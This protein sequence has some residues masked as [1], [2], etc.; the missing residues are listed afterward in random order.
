MFKKKNSFFALG[1]SGLVTL[2]II[3]FQPNINF[4]YDFESFFP[5][6]DGEL[7]FYQEFR[8]EF[9]NDNDYLLIA[10]GHRPDVFDS[11]FLEKASLLKKTIKGMERVEKVISLLDLEEPMIS[12]FGIRSQPL[13]EWDEQ[14]NLTRSKN[15]ILESNQWKKNLINETGNYILLL[16]HNQQMISKEEGDILYRN[17]FG[18]VENSGFTDFYIAGKIQAQGEFVNLMQDEFSSFLGISGVLIVLLLFL[19]FRTLW[20]ILIPLI[21][22]MIGFFWSIAIPLYLGKPLDI[23]SVM[24]PTILS[25]IGLAA[26]IHFFNQYLNYLRHG[27]TKEDAIEKSFLEILPAVFLTSLTTALGFASLYFTSVPTLKFFGLYTGLGVLV[28]FLSVILIIPGLLYIVPAFKQKNEEKNAENWRIGMR[29]AFSFVLLNKKT[30]PLI[31]LLIT[32]S[33]LFGVSRLKVNGYILDNLPVG[34][35]LV[36]GFDFFDKNFGGSKPLEFSLQVGE[37]AENIFQMEVLKEMEKFE[38]FISDNFETGAIISP[39]SLVKKMNQA[40]NSGNEK[41]YAFPSQGQ[42]IRLKPYL[43]EALELSPVKIVSDD[44]K[45]SRIS[46]R[47][48]DYGSEKGKRLKDKMEAFLESE[49]NQ[50][51]LVVRMTGTSHLIDIS[52]ESVTDQMLRGLVFA[53]F[54]VALITGLLFRSWRVSI[55]ILVP[56]IIPLIWMG[57]MMWAFGIDLKLTTAILFTVAFGI[58]VDDSIHFMS[59]LR[60]ELNKGRTWLYALKRTFIDTGK[61]ITLTTIILVSGFS[62]LIFSQFGVTFYS[63]LLISFSLVFA[64]VADLL[65]LP[66]LLLFIGKRL[67]KV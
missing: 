56:N 27:Y 42:L 17:I 38:R 43:K 62:V 10:L 36:E 25:V 54:L 7:S 14:V 24:Q 26:I 45:W 67:G 65:L 39:L 47:V 50:A 63:G 29:K 58:A 35:E 22:L 32:I 12:P 28:M 41:A 18:A 60:L 16:V 13:L 21:A 66:L 15:R 61:A 31:F 20:G 30:I 9:G 23:M 57:G 19:I 6:D 53:F 49:V 46:T 37:E 5:Q 55:I 4:D 64:L 44:L 52:H 2:G 48:E 59:K 11:G 8:S 40:Q 34:H 51:Y 33:C 1:L 3:F